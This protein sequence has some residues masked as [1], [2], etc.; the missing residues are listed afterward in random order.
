MKNVEVKIFFSNGSS[1]SIPQFSFREAQLFCRDRISYSSNR[2]K[3]VE[4]VTPDGTR[5]MWDSAW[6]DESKYAGLRLTP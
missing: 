5:A 3:R 4:I 1:D 2:V 6:D